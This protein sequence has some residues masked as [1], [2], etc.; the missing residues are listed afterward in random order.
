MAN[1]VEENPGPCSY[2]IVDPSKTITADFSQSNARKFRHNAGKQCVA[3]SL[4]A[5]AQTQVKD[6]TTWDSSFLNTILSVGNNLY[7]YIQNSINK[8]YLLLSD[9]P[10]MVPIDNKVYCLEY[11]E[12]FSGDVFKLSDDEPFYTLKTALNKIFSPT[13]LNYQHCL[14]TVDCNTVA[15]CMTS[16]R[17]FKIFDSHSR[18]SYG[19]PDPFGKCVLIHVQALDNLSIFF[20]NTYPPNITKPFK[21]KRG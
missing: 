16:E 7:T 2:D 3:M 10:E 17:T 13:E 4:T 5:I 6:I 19:I 15:I 11:S 9:V 20:Q 14:L 1:D 18:D 8:D 12:S 21:E